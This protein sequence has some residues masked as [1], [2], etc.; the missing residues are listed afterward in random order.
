MEIEEFALGDSWV[1]GLDPR[2]KIVVTIIFSIIVALN[3]SIHVA[4][5][6]LILPLIL[7]I[8][9][10]LDFRKL[11]VRLAI[12]NSFILFLWLFLPFST[13]GETICSIGPLN[14][15][16]EGLLLA[17]LITLKSNSIILMAIALLGTSQIFSL[18]HA[19][20]HL[21]VPDKLVHLFFFCFRY[22]HVVHGEY[23][24]LINAMKMRGFRPK[25][26]MHTYRAYSYLVG[27]LLIRSFDRSKRILD[28]MR[29]R[30]FK[31]K[32][33]ILH[34]YEMKRCDYALAGSSLA[35]S[36][37]LMVVR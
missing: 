34:N 22:I 23:H 4:G 37:L 20:S 27:M 26:N 13:P 33:Y 2:V 21:F 30:G 18:V 29:C 12:V 28:A 35:F 8:C 31:G 14:I 32:F 17:A 16:R 9:A 6:S 1:H 36:I 11:M 7:V 24:R 25:T 15:Q 10:R 5:I 3:S 19:L